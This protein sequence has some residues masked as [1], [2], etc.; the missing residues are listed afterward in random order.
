[1]NLLAIDTSSINF[2]LCLI[3]S[4][5]K[6]NVEFN[7]GITH[8]SVALSEVQKILK[9]ANVAFKD[10]NVIAFSAGPGS[11]TGIRIACGVAYGIAFSH[12]IP[13]TGISSLKTI[14]SM[15]ESNY[16]LSTIDARMGEVY[17]QF[18]KRNND[19]KIL[20]LSEP[21]VTAPD[22]LPIPPDEITNRFSVIGTGYEMFTDH[23]NDTYLSYSLDN[24][25]L[26]TNMASYIASIALEQ[27]PDKFS[28]DG[29]QPIYVRN[30]VAQTIDERK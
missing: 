2:S 20:P 6:E 27:P 13:L 19:K 16:I 22:K 5:G 9:K 15:T 18:F 10:L 30:K 3:H 23:F 24:Q 12:K 17:L 8:S 29:I 1:L 4:A 25:N 7:A 11:F 28:F 14:A 26:K 21:M